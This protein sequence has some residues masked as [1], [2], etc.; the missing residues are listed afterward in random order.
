MVTSNSVVNSAV[1]DVEHR[2]FTVFTSTRKVTTRR[3]VRTIPVRP[4]L[5]RTAIATSFEQ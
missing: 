4:E 5:V 1:E 3:I 2:V